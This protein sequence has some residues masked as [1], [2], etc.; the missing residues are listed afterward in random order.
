MDQPVTNGENGVD[1]YVYYRH[2]CFCH[3]LN[4]PPGFTPN[5]V[6]CR[7]CGDILIREIPGTNYRCVRCGRHLVRFK[8]NVHGDVSMVDAHDSFNCQLSELGCTMQAMIEELRLL[9]NQLAFVS[10]HFNTRRESE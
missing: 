3:T 1:V 2:P 5:T 7:Q 6:A 9:Q 10:M 4:E 8:Q